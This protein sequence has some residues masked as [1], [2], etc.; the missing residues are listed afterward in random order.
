[1]SGIMGIHHLNSHP[2][3]HQDLEK[4]VDIL[5][6]RGP[7]HA[8]IWIEEFVGLGHRML[9]TTPESLIEKL[10]LINQAGNLVITADARIDNRD[11]LIALLKLPERSIEKITDS[12][13]IL[14][15]YEKWGESCPEYL[16]GDFAFAIWDKR[17]QSLFCARDHFGIKP[18]YYYYQPNQ[19]FLFASEIKAL[20]CVPDVPRRLNEVRIA[21]YL[22]LMMTD[23]AI[24]TYQDILR[25]PP[26]HSLVIN[27]SGIY[28]WSYWSLDDQRELQL[29]SNAAYAEE[30]R[31]IFI[32]AVNCRL[33][34]AFAIASHLSG[35]LDSSAV[36]CVAR[37]LLAKEEKIQLHTIS[38]IFDKITE[39]DERPFIN[40][41]LDQ[42]G[43]IPHYAHGEQFSPLSDL[44]KI[45][46]YEDEALLGPSHF[47]PW[48]LNRISQEM[49]LRIC[50]DGF[51]GDTTVGHGTTRLTELL[52]Q[53]KWQTFAQEVKALSPHH[54]VSH[55]AVL[56]SYGLPY[57]RDLAKQW[58]WI[59]FAQ[60]V[61]QIHQHFG[62]SRKLLVIHHGIKPLLEPILQLWRQW[63]KQDKS[64]HLVS[65]TSLVNPD[66]A[67]RIRLDERM[68]ILA[69]STLP[70]L[71]VKEEQWRSLTQGLLTYTLEQMDQYAAM[72]SVEAR[73]PFMDKRLIEF[74]LAL[75]AEQKLYQGWGR[76]VMR[77]AL[78][79]ILPKEVQWRGGKTDLTANFVD[80]L[81]NRDRQLLDEVML[82]RLGNIEKFIDIDFLRAAYQRLISTDNQASNADSMA[83]WQAVTLAL[84]LDYKQVML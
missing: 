81:L 47:Y 2:I 29:E 82:N 57:L 50:L 44:D 54:N 25:L 49:G 21:D 76:M 43:F 24:T 12:E 79:G 6:H 36:T 41:V 45:F 10:P 17:Q 56:Q 52:H 26:A 42:G 60:G 67:E 78:E 61:Q 71:T 27:Q 62:V 40:A 65:Q 39:C 31:K 46:Q 59:A 33:R 15:A 48:N 34:S 13:F 84:W 35:G 72:F 73:H 68:Q 51:D 14:A 83:V 77:R 80:G 70:P 5:A 3:N 38:T 55:A 58:R 11:Q 30:F 53:G 32:E 4:M 64:P 74:C 19:I 63:R 9:W 1:M 20:F 37:N 8:D 22:A 18:F 66:F 28:I 23:K 75:P 7:D 69:G 16:L